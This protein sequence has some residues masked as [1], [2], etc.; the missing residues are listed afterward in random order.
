M[1]SQILFVYVHFDGEMINTTEEGYVFQSRKKI[2]MR[3]NKCISLADLK[4]KIS[5]KIATRCRKQMLILFYKFSVSTDPLKF[6]K[7]ELED[8]DD[9]GTM[10]AIYCPPKIENPSPVELFA[11]IAEP[12]LIQVVVIGPFRSGSLEKNQK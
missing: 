10:I 3:F 1:S 7:I 8:D 12:D 4:Q 6:S 9:L 2:G 5:T 11:K